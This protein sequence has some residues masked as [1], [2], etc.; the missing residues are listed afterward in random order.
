MI[1]DPLQA[2]RPQFAPADTSGYGVNVKTF[3]AVPDDRRDDTAAIQAAINSIPVPNDVAARGGVV[4]IPR[5]TFNVTSLRLPSAIQLVGEGEGTYLLGRG[6]APTISLIALF[7]HGYNT[8][9]VVR[10]MKIF[11]PT[12]ECIS[13]D[14]KT[15]KNVSNC[16]LENLHLRS[17][18][19]HFAI[20][21]DAYSQDCVLQ[22]IKVLNYGGGAAT[23]FGNANLIDRI[24]TEGE[25]GD[26]EF[27][28]EPAR[29]TVRGAGNTISGCIIES[30][31][32]PAVAFYVEGSVT[33]INNWMEVITPKDGIAYHFK[34]CWG[35]F[36]DLK[37]LGE[38][39]R[40][41][42]ENCQIM[43]FS[44]LDVR[45]GTLANTFIMDDKSNVM[46]D[47]LVTQMDSGWL[48]NDQFKIRRVFNEHAKAILDNPPVSRGVDLI[49]GATAAAA[50]GA[51]RANNA[52]DV[53][54]WV[55]RDPMNQPGEAAKF[56]VVAETNAAGESVLRIDVKSNPDKHSIGVRVPL[57]VPPELVGKRAVLQVKLDPGIFLWNKSLTHNY[58]IRVFG[59]RTM[60]ATP[61]LEAQDEVILVLQAPEAGK[62]VRITGLSVT[63]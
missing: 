6:D 2:R 10:E 29:L 24:N 23:I 48:D 57:V 39:H 46:V 28:C 44:R 47:L 9:A 63:K 51:A 14:A 42:M 21:L 58:P 34:D 54:T 33:W 40:V 16:R 27:A 25:D 49:R 18:K 11:S 38:K 19:G 17:G 59:E 12:S 22:N 36:D 26:K 61:P 53:S 41:K 45:S 35:Q 56:D 31:S 15:V 5:G 50:N 20:R 7:G 4:Y 52:A 30:G 62:S 43:Q 13:L 3:G 60:C 8:G 55:V 37:L 1:Q 32:K